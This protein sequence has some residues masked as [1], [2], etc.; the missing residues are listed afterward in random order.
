MNI[1]VLE[2]GETGALL[3]REDRRFEHLT[4]VLHKKP[5][6]SVL[7]GCTDG[8]IGR[9]VILR[10]DS[11]GLALDFIPEGEAPP[12]YSIR[13]ILGFPRPIQAA[14]IF[15]DLGSLGVGEIIL[16]GTDLGEK[17]YIQ[18]DFFSKG[19]YRRSL[20]EG[21]EQAGSPRLPTI[22]R[23]W[24]LDRCLASLEFPEA[25][26]ENR[27][28][29]HPAPEHPPFS[30]LL[31]CDG[32]KN[33]RLTLAVGSERGWTERECVALGEAGF[34]PASLGTRILKTE[35]AALTAVVLALA[36]MSLL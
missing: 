11:G 20:V 22:L 33:R 31:A 19:E 14:R 35:T 15:K 6:D 23:H 9:A 21:A 10:M 12:L 29:L 3:P 25:P 32:R 7:A 13:L 18:S 26:G 2:P 36:S 34:H 28:F 5:G 24:T 1:L 8:R 17:S 4:K 16:T 30:A 27:Y